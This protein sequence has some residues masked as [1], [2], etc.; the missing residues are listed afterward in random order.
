MFIVVF[1]VVLF[2]YFSNK[3]KF[4]L[5]GLYDLMRSRVCWFLFVGEKLQVNFMVLFMLPISLSFSLLGE[6]QT[7]FI[8]LFNFWRNL[9]SKKQVYMKY[10]LGR[11][12]RSWW[13]EE[14]FEKKKAKGS[15]KNIILKEEKERKVEDRIWRLVVFFGIY[16]TFTVILFGIEKI[17]TISKK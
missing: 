2:F 13:K 10:W 15:K 11:R 7:V 6:S 9:R 8:Y 5:Y 12:R 1:K 4:L 3:K 17:V 14:L 16:S